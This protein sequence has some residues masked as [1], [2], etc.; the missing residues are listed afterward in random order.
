MYIYL[1]R[2]ASAEWH[3]TEVAGPNPSIFVW[4]LWFSLPVQTV[5]KVIL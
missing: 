4:M 5:A 1:M 2:G 3:L